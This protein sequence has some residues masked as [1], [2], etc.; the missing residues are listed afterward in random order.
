MRNLPYFLTLGMLVAC[1]IPGD[2]PLLDLTADDA[3]KICKRAVD[4]SAEDRVVDCDGTEVT[5]E[6]TTIADCEAYFAAVL[7][8]NNADCTGTL[9]TWVNCQEE[10]DLTDGQVCGTE[11][12]TISSDCEM[13]VVTCLTPG[14]GTTMSTM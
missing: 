7:T 5:L 14:G 10:P 3:T 12:Y 9:D 4:E 1:G 8:A 2:T 6:A 11:T 13:A